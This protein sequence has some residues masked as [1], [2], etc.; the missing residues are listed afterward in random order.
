MRKFIIS[1]IHGVGNVYYAIMGYLDNLSKEEEIELY[2]NGDLIDRGP[3]SANVLLD[4]K[5]RVE[6]KKYKIVSQQ[7]I[8]AR[9]I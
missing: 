3:D 6:G 4:I 9:I 5:K 1:D 8:L 7:D 2:I